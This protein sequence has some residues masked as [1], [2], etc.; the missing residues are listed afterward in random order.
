MGLQ[1]APPQLEAD[2]SVGA[3]R[4]L[5][6]RA[7]DERLVEEIQRGNQAAFEVVYDRH[8]RELLSFCRHM[9]GSHEEA[10]EALQ[11]SFAGAWAYL[12]RDRPAPPLLKPWLYAIARNRCLS[13]LRARRPEQAELDDLPSTADL[14]DE[15]GGRAELRALVADLQR[16]PEEMRTALLLSELGDLR[17]ADIADVLGRN[18][19]GV[20]ALVFRA[21][22]TLIALREARDTTC[23]QVR[24][25]LSV[26]RRG[27]LR[28]QTRWH[29]QD[30]PEC[31]AF[32]HELKAQRARIALI[33]PIVPSAELKCAVLATA[34][35][36]GGAASGGATAGG[37]AVAGLAALSP[38]ALGSATAATVAVVSVI[39]GGGLVV[40][41]NA[42]GRA[43]PDR[44]AK[45]PVGTPA[46][47]RAPRADT[48]T[49]GAPALRKPRHDPAPQAD[50]GA[51][52]EAAREVPPELHP[53]PAGPD[54]NPSTAAQAS[55]AIGPR[56]T[57]GQPRG[58]TADGKSGPPHGNSGQSR[59][60][61]GQS[62]GN[63]GRPRDNSGQSRGNS[64]QPHGNSGRPRDKS[65]QP[66]GKS[67]HARGNS[68]R[69]HGNSGQ[70]HGNSGYARGKSGQPQAQSPHGPA[71]RGE[72][73]RRK[74][75]TAAGHRSSGGLGAS[76]LGRRTP[77]P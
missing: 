64:G 46:N 26:L 42:P 51:E 31:R 40:G 67:G 15:V 72:R 29:L 16:L 11:H 57:S 13:L 25:Q 34:G 28:R 36:G 62:R 3:S 74:P 49:P 37:S 24:E 69:P 32:R 47:D 71:A 55:V 53:R 8:C 39:A 38:P 14:T 7:R 20:K 10:E 61:S 33:L 76:A 52:P 23:E 1:T 45:A 65:G 68:G 27:A 50:L 60:N 21:R 30:C 48:T 18:E 59:G 54:P 17:H 63:S 73:Q 4:R 9:L 66:H 35:L 22:S 58:N 44:F 19:A 77:Q 41:E 75:R 70:P 5:L 6:R 12:Q 2:R 56:S 43:P